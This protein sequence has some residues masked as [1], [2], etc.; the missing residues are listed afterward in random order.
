MMQVA[1]KTDAIAN[2]VVSLRSDLYGGSAK[3]FL[4]IPIWLK[5]RALWNPLPEALDTIW[6]KEQVR[7][8]T[9]SQ[10]PT[11]TTAGSGI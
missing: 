5:P 2:G 6:Q 9:V 4:S 11:K 7:V 8:N 1:Y 10:S 3:Y